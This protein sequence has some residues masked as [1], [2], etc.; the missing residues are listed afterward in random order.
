MSRG[1]NAEH[2]WHPTAHYDVWEERDEGRNNRRREVVCCHCG[3]RAAQ[4]YR[5]L[6]GS[7]EPGH[8]LHAR[9]VQQTGIT[10]PY[11]HHAIH[12][13]PASAPGTRS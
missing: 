8:G 2:C 9:H 13:C 11:P 7:D 4:H 1:Q 3:L 5:I 10:Y 12:E 6:P